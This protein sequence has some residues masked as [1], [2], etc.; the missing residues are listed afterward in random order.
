MPEIKGINPPTGY[1]RCNSPAGCW[2]RTDQHGETW[3][4]RPYVVWVGTS[5]VGLPTVAQIGWD[6]S[7]GVLPSE[8]D[9]H[10]DAVRIID[11][12]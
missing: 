12:Y 9:A 4:A 8:Y 6:T 5:S 3:F 1:R 11:G 7:R 10:E 2:S